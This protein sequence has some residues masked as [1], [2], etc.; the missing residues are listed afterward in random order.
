MKLKLIAE[1]IVYCCAQFEWSDCNANNESPCMIKIV[2]MPRISLINF[3]SEMRVAKR[4]A[5]SKAQDG[6]WCYAEWIREEPC[7]ACASHLQSIPGIH[8]PLQGLDSDTRKTHLH[9]SSCWLSDFC[10]GL[11]DLQYFMGSTWSFAWLDLNIFWKYAVISSLQLRKLYTLF[12][13]AHLLEKNHVDAY[14]HISSHTVLG[15]PQNGAVFR[16]ESW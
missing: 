7:G 5:C 11:L 10:K 16:S 6:V 3:L 8:W 12:A 4:D 2:D 13:T 9:Q 1:I 14:Q 15:L